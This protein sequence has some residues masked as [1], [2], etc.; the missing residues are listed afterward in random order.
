M[1]LQVL[2]VLDGAASRSMIRQELMLPP[3]KDVFIERLPTSPTP[4]K[5]WT[6]DN[7]K[8]ALSSSY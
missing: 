5:N 8:Q 4:S 6:M 1:V 7:M 3:F 2:A